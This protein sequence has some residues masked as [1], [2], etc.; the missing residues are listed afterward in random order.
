MNNNLCWIILGVY[1]LYNLI[2]F[3]IYVSNHFRSQR[4]LPRFHNNHLYQMAWWLG[5]LG[6]WL[7][8]FLFK[9]KKHRRDFRRWLP[10]LAFFQPILMA[11][12]VWFVFDMTTPKCPYCGSRQAAYIIYG[13][14]KLGQDDFQKDIRK[15]D[16]VIGE[17]YI[18]RDNAR[19]QCKK[20]HAK[21]GERE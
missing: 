11:I 19:Y 1:I 20:C 13:K 7:A 21:F 16:K 18:G 5:G 12:V 8:M 17:Y 3:G 6:A 4:G 14:N 15:G 2:V 10:R 9:A